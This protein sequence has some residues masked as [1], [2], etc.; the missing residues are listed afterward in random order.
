MFLLEEAKRLR[1]DGIVV[2][3]DLYD[4]RYAVPVD[5]QNAFAEWVRCVTAAGLKLYLLPGNHDQIDIQG[6]N[7]L[8]VFNHYPSVRVISDPRVVEGCAWLPYRKDPREMEKWAQTF[9]TPVA[10]MHHGVAGA[11]MNDHIV[12]GTSH[13]VMPGPFAHFL[14]VI[15]GHWHRPQTL[16][17]YVY[18]GSPYQTSLEE[19]GQDKFFVHVDTDS[20]ASEFIRVNVG[21]RYV[22]KYIGVDGVI[23]DDV[24]TGDIVVVSLEDGAD[25]DVIERRLL[26]RGAVVRMPPKIVSTHQRSKLS[27]TATPKEHALSYIEAEPNADALTD[28]FNRAIDQ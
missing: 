13:G 14:K 27:A 7:A 10:F 6:A 18:C 17:N 19:A 20:G 8:E 16:G 2:V 22:H 23:A 9:K 1:V 28:F 4:I 24:R 26:E 11:M 5:V 3:G 21:P 12:A 25:R 15:C